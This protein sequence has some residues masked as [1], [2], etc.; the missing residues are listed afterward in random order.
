[1][2]H[3]IMVPVDLAHTDRLDR[4]LSCAADLA[5]SHGAAVTYVG[6][7]GAVPGA[8]AHTPQEYAEKLAAFARAEA[9][10]R[11]IDTHAHAVTSHD[12]AVDLDKTLLKAVRDTGADL[13]VMATHV[14]NVTDYVWAA[15]GADVAAHT[16]AS[17]F[18]VRG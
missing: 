9:D 16:D 14:P 6:V 4:A 13:V 12:P 11:G 15:H 3:K 10:A 7:T 18:L 2:F 5:R 8:V 17:V 1:M